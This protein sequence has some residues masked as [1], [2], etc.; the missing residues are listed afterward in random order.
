MTQHLFVTPDR[1]NFADLSAEIER[2]GGT[3]HWAAS[4]DQALK[5]IKEQTVDLVVTDERLGDM[6]GLDLV[7]RLVAVNPMINSAAVSSLSKEAFHEASEG[8]GISMQLPPSPSRA[9]GERLMAHLNQIL[10]FNAA[11][12]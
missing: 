7:G 8:L 11:E 12:R 3:V 1:S 10:G 4:G 9:D 6:T 2:Q 5:T